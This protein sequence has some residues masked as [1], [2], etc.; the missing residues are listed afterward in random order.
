MTMQ[1]GKC[2][3]TG[4]ATDTGCFQYSNT[5][6]STFRAA[7]DLLEFGVPVSDINE[8]IFETKRPARLALESRVLSG[9]RYYFGGKCA[10]IVVTEEMKQQYGVA[11]EELEGLAS[12]P[13]TVEGVELAVTIKQ[14]PDGCRIS[15]RT[16]KPVDAAALCAVFGGGGHV[17]AGGCFIAAPAEQALERILDAA[18]QN[19][20]SGETP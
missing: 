18:R 4:M 3:Y 8:A 11:D 19:I 15:V 13:R 17:R 6:P 2:L 20:Y 10:V 12:I 9:M 7:A 16:S 5:H 1:V 14:K